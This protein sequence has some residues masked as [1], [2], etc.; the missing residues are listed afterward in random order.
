MLLLMKG[1]LTPILLLPVTTS[2]LVNL[3]ALLAVTLSPLR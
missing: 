1:M 3:I 2:I